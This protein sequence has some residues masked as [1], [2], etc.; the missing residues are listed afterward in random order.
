MVDYEEIQ[1]PPDN[2]NC[3][4]LHKIKPGVENIFDTS[5]NFIFE[6]TEMNIYI[7]ERLDSHRN[8]YA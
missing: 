3:Y 8:K 5:L 6:C 7:C 2:Y 4:G 1:V